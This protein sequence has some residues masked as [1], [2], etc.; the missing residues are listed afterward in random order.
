MT[1]LCTSNIDDFRWWHKKWGQPQKWRQHWKVRMTSWTHS[2]PRHLLKTSEWSRVCKTEDRRQDIHCPYPGDQFELHLTVLRSDKTL[3][4]C[5]Y[6]SNCSISFKMKKE[7]DQTDLLH[8][9]LKEL[10]IST[11]LLNLLDLLNLIN[12]YQL[13]GIQFTT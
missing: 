13:D 1:A 11:L 7:Q 5:V 10:P 2:S 12:V 3:S 6:W 8:Q 9:F 4:L